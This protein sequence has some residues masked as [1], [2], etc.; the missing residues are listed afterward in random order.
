MTTQDQT[1]LAAL[2]ADVTD[3][4]RGAASWLE[5]NDTVAPQERQSLTREFR[6]F[7]WHCDK[8]EQAALRPMCVG[9]FGPSQSGKS[10]LIS[11][12]A[13]PGTEPLIA[14]FAGVP[15]GMDF[16]G[17]INPEGGKE[18]TGL[19]TRF[20]IRPVETPADYPVAVRLLSEAD[21]LKIIG[22]FYYSDLDL[23]DAVPP[24][25]QRVGEVIA[26]LRG[27]LK[28]E[29]QGRMSADDIADIRDY[30]H[31]E[32]RDRCPLVGHDAAGFWAFA[33]E[34]AP[35]LAVDDRAALFGLLWGEA[36]TLSSLYVR[37]YKALEALGFPEIAH[38]PL[39]ALHRT[40]ADGLPAGADPRTGSIIDVATLEG[41]LDGEDDRLVVRGAADRTADLPRPVVTALV[42][43]LIIVA[44][45]KPHDFFEHVD[46]LDFPGAR[47]RWNDPLEI[48]LRKP[49]GL[50]ELFLRGK[51]AYLFDR[52]GAD[53][54][55]T[56][57]LLCLGPENKEVLTLP[58][59]IDGWV[60]RTHGATPAERA[61]QE[62]ALFLVLTKFDLVFLRKKGESDTSTQR[63]QTLIETALTQYLGKSHDWVEQWA[64]N[65]PFANTFWLRNP[66]AIADFLFDYE[67]GQESRLRSDMETRVAQMRQ[68]Y[69]V[70][71]AVQRHVGDPQ[72][73]WDEAFRLNDGGVTYL[74]ERLT[75]LCRPDIKTRQLRQRLSALAAMMAERLRPFYV[76]SDMDQEREKRR[77]E[78]RIVLKSLDRAIQRRRF[79]HLRAL[80]AVSP[81]D[82]E[83]V[84]YRVATAP[85]EDAETNPADCDS[86]TGIDIDSLLSGDDPFAPA[87]EAA[88]PPP[89]ANDLAARYARAVLTH[90]AEALSD[91]TIDPRRL[92]R[93]GIEERAM[94]SLTR[95]LIEGSHRLAVERDIADSVRGMTQATQRIEQIMPR[96]AAAAATVLNRFVDQLGF[97]RRPPEERPATRR[98]GTRQPIFQP[99]PPV[100][101]LPELPE[102]G[103]RFDLAGLVD[104]LAGYARLVDEN[105]QSLDGRTIDVEANDRLGKLL[106]RIEPASQPGG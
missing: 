16:V 25:A 9:V 18:S 4:A 97:D 6:R 33:E 86:G 19:V 47:S 21:I 57:M 59:L 84:Y 88:A 58:R 5:T 85:M 43:E 93:L 27:R 94:V 32:F 36:E 44:D 98:N 13:R 91:L 106:A 23:K 56:S 50:K 8:L 89:P 65:R 3:A 51:V 15:G 30:L 55:L 64:P 48:V 53:L 101:D 40:E 66:N 11:A 105:A 24:S 100:A 39:T 49:D 12:L 7:A 83:A 72:R 20:T 22:N 79:G 92:A 61:K 67:D 37:L 96:I 95:E 42:A 54:E 45:K 69:L 104:W 81:D 31:A 78:A 82:L 41:L 10:Y 62:T 34:A 74:A 28:P 75:P 77:G 103:L 1:A 71:E 14:R 68:E 76:S 70:T 46:L 73:A 102:D 60:T 99:P 90:W 63:W 80:L 52:Y 29:P 87:P 26:R 2:C 38:C 35:R 17:K